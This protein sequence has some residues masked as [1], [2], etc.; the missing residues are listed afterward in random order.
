M[1]TSPLK[2]ALNQ[3]LQSSPITT[4]PT[5]VALGAIKQSFPKLGR[6]PFT[7]KITGI[8]YIFCPLRLRPPAEKLIMEK[9]GLLF[10]YEPGFRLLY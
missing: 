7:G 10:F 4:S 6:T 3:M 1:F 9:I 2:T 5:I 8:K